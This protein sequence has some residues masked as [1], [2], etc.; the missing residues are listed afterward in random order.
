MS[1]NETPPHDYYPMPRHIREGYLPDEIDL[2]C[3][4]DGVRHDAIVLTQ[5]DRDLWLEIF[6]HNAKKYME[7]QGITLR[8][9]ESYN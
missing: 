9:L 2:R 7:R 4:S 3:F 1:E 5:Q 8:S 6:R